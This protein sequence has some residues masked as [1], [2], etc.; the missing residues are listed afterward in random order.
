MRLLTTHT[1]RSGTI[2]ATNSIPLQWMY[3]VPYGARTSV[4]GGI[5]I[6]V[7]IYLNNC[8]YGSYLIPIAN[9]FGS[10]PTKLTIPPPSACPCRTIFHTIVSYVAHT[11]VRWA[12]R[13]SM[14][15]HTWSRKKSRSVSRSQDLRKVTHTLSPAALLVSGECPLSSITTLYATSR[16]DLATPGGSLSNKKNKITTL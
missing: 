5:Y 16:E 10:N 13:T 3:L 11:I 2:G 1:H 12:S 14:I 9:W 7:F 15:S 6:P 4:R 8:K